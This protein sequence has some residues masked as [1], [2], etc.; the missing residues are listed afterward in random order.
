[1]ELAEKWLPTLLCI[2]NDSIQYNDLLR[3]SQTVKDI[4]DIEDW[5]LSIYQ[6]KGYLCEE[7]AKDP[8]LN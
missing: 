7:I 8:A 3:N 6:F 1:M 5:L 4:A 2:I